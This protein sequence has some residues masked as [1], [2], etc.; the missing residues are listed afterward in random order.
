MQLLHLPINY[1]TAPRYRRTEEAD[2][3]E[4]GG[5]EADTT[6]RGGGRERGREAYTTERGGGRER[7][8]AVTIFDTD[9]GSGWQGQRHWWL[10]GELVIHLYNTRHLQVTPPSRLWR[11]HDIATAT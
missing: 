9:F 11:R 5:R 10:E 7:G 2:T 8:W 1:S 6:E 4:R 3:T